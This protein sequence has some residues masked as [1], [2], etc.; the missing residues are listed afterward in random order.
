[1]W[2][3]SS[4][5]RCSCSMQWDTD[6]KLINKRTIYLSGSGKHCGGKHKSRKGVIGSGM[7]A[8]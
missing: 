4:S 8:L 5:W 7:A 1:M 6:N 2:H 3:N